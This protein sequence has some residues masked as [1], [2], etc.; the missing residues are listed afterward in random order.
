MNTE[1]FECYELAGSICIR[2]LQEVEIGLPENLQPVGLPKSVETAIKRQVV[3][4]LQQKW[5]VQISYNFD[6]QVGVHTLSS[7]LFQERVVKFCTYLIPL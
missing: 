3:S 1:I 7:H 2:Y 4:S 5:V 6:G